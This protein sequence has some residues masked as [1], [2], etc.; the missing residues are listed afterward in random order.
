M[1]QKKISA[2]FQLRRDTASN[3]EAK[4][5]VLLDGEKIIVVT[6][7]GKPDSRLATA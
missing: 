6:A 2:R 1:S 4:N 7:A 3:W 5:E